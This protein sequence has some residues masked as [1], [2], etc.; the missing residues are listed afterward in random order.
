MR[1]ILQWKWSHLAPTLTSSSQIWCFVGSHTM[2]LAYLRTFWAHSM[3]KGCIHFSLC[4]GFNVFLFC[5]INVLTW[6]IVSGV[7]IEDIVIWFDLHHREEIYWIL[8][9]FESVKCFWEVTSSKFYICTNKVSFIYTNNWHQIFIVVISC[10]A[11]KVFWCLQQQ[12]D[13]CWS[14]NIHSLIHSFVVAW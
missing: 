5:M 3:S 2:K 12:K 4:R 6:D 8:L 9:Q 13:N 7:I 10:M 14:F 11:R 1:S